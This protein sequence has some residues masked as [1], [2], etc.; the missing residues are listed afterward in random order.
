MSITDRFGFND[1]NWN[2]KPIR[3]EKK[4]LSSTIALSA[5]ADAISTV[6]TSGF[7]DTYSP[8]DWEVTKPTK[9]GSDSSGKRLKHGT[10]YR[11]KVELAVLWQVGGNPRN[12]RVCC[13]S[14]RL[15]RHPE[16]SCPGQHWRRNN[17]R[18]HPRR[19][20]EHLASIAI[21]HGLPWMAKWA[22]STARSL[23]RKN[24]L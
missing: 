13:Q 14:W 1:P 5:T 24:R 8:S 23:M 15:G 16:R 18:R 22:T 4:W 3:E 21:A 17:P 12:I 20:G 10:C 9:S 19:L 11:W 2:P 6:S 7:W